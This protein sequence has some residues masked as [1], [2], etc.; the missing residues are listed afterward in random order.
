MKRALLLGAMAF[1]LI[2]D[3]FIAASA[4]QPTPTPRTVY[5]QPGPGESILHANP[6]LLGNLLAG[7][8]SLTDVNRSMDAACKDLGVDEQKRMG[9]FY[10]CQEN[11]QQLLERGL[12]R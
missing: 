2:A 5:R 1:A 6:D 3:T 11:H 12:A 7:M 9:M 10:Q 4:Q 8:P